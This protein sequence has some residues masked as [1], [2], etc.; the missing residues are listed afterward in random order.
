MIQQ[1]KSLGLKA[2]FLTGDGGCT[3]EFIKL[4]GVASEGLCCALP[5]VPLDQMPGGKAFSD[6]FCAQYGQMPRN[7][8]YVYDAVMVMVDAMKRTGSV[9]AAK[10]LPMISKANYNGV[11]T[12]LQFDDKGNLKIRPRTVSGSFLKSPARHLPTKVPMK[13][14]M[15]EAVAE[16]GE[17]A[18]GRR[19]PPSLQPR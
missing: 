1:M 8:P 16:R 9:E 11:T 15:S 12:K 13:T 4:A 7:A 2:K 18:K 10:F 3:Q 19:Q 5:G 14:T 6:A 17:A